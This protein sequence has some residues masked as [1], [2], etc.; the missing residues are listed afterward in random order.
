MVSF[1]LVHN[2]IPITYG[3]AVRDGTHHSR[4]Q[5]AIA[6]DRGI[7]AVGIVRQAGEQG[8]K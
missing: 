1:I 8:L 6:R 7:E 2:V 4:I 3:P 5:A